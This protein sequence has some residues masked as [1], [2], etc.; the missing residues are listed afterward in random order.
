MFLSCDWRYGK[1]AICSD[2]AR[3]GVG[4]TQPLKKEMKTSDSHVNKC[5]LPADC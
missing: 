5:L 1:H 4:I 3:A 2:H